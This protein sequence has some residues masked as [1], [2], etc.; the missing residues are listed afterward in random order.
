M[1]CSLLHDH[2]SLPI[3]RTLSVENLL[4]SLNQS[5]FSKQ[6]SARLQQFGIDSAQNRLM[7]VVDSFPSSS[8]SI[9]PKHCD[10]LERSALTKPQETRLSS[11][12]DEDQ[13]ILNDRKQRRML[14][15]RESARRSRL[16]KQQH[17]DELRAH[18]ARL[19]AENRQM[20]NS[21]NL[22]SQ[23]YAQLTH[24]NKILLSEA[25]DLSHR[26][27]LLNQTLAIRYSLDWPQQT[28]HQ[29]FNGFQYGLDSGLPQGLLL[30]SESSHRPSLS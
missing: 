27:K 14:S 12:S 24:E 2:H 30:R 8:P 7:G 16:R 18:V 10:E 11:N 19:R 6:Q 21:F 25:T 4:A 17:L 22:A 28:A 23:R 3:S 9:D 15:N 13:Q 5:Y 20:I 26:L 1:G 29:C